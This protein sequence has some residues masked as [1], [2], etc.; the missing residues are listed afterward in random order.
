MKKYVYSF[1]EGIAD[2]FMFPYNLKVWTT[3]LDQ[4]SKAW[5]ADRVA[6]GGAPAAAATPH[7][8]PTSSPADRPPR[9]AAQAMGT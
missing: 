1:G 7:R 2:A 3:P 9:G 5:I 8:E 6:A 4:M